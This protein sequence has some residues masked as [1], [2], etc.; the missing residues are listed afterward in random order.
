VSG[1]CDAAAWGKGA[2]RGC[3]P[4]LTF[5][6]R[7]GF[8]HGGSDVQLLGNSDEPVRLRLIGQF[9]DEV[10]GASGQLAQA[11]GGSACIGSLLAGG[12]SAAGFGDGDAADVALGSRRSPRRLG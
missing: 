8:E 1:N 12:T 10:A 3:R 2:R 5:D 11:G 9:L 4:D 7:A 6:R